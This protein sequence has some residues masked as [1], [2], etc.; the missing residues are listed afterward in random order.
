MNKLYTS[1]LASWLDCFPD[2]N[3]IQKMSPCLTLSIIRYRLRV[4][5]VTQGKK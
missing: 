2:S 3:S 5:G 1:P 4:R